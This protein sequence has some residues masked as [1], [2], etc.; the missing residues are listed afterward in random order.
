MCVSLNRYFK[1]RNF[2]GFAIFSRF[3]INSF[4]KIFYNLADLAKTS[5]NLAICESLFLLNK[6]IFF[7]LAYFG[8]IW[9]NLHLLLGNSGS[10]CVNL[11]L[12][13]GCFGLFWIVLARFVSFGSF[14]SHFGSFWLVLGLL[15]AHFVFFWVV[16]GRFR[17]LL[18]CF[19]FFLVILAQFRSPFGSFWVSF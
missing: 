16:L 6:K 7:V 8:S 17:S 3:G 10:F 11:V 2:R 19:V 4:R 14:R 13:F 5:S 18:A 1:G 12:L 15:L 9:V